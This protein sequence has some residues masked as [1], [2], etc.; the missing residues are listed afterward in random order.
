M[1][2]TISLQTSPFQVRQSFYGISVITTEVAYFTYMYANIDKKDYKKVTSY[3][4][5][6]IHFGQFVSGLVGQLLLSLSILDFEELNYLSLGGAV[7]AL[8]FS[9]F[10]PRVL[11]DLDEKPVAKSNDDPE[12]PMRKSE[13][14]EKAP[15]TPSPQPPTGL[16]YTR[17]I[18]QPKP[19]FLQR[20]R[21]SPRNAWESLK[22]AYTDP[23]I[24]KWSVW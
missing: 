19:G 15:S 17:N 6:A 1:H 20:W 18:G 8:T 23:G 4:H 2:T 7:G 24:I 9:L 11:R 13:D 12:T 3:T 16:N 10:L 21:E 22:Y 5:S 14:P